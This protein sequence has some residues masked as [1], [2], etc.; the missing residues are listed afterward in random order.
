MKARKL[1]E[2]L[3]KWR[4]MGPRAAVSRG[5]KPDGLETPLSTL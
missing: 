2:L 4:H 3:E 5:W 1:L